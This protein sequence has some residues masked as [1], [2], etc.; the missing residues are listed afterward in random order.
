MTSTTTSRPGARGPEWPTWILI[1]CIYGSWAGL[2]LGYASLPTWLSNPALILVTTW[3]MS[4]QH[5]LLHGHPT[6][7]AGFNRLLG[8][9]PLSAWYPYDIY[10]DS[11]LLHHR[12]ALLTLPGTDPESNYLRAEDYSRMGWFSRMLHWSMRTVVGRLLLGPGLT[13]AQVWADIWTG[14]RERGLSAVKTWAVHLGLLAMVLWWV[15]S[16]SGITPLHYLLG[17][18]YP[19]L[20]LAMLRSF[21]E[22]RPAQDPAHRIVIN[23]AGLFWG[24]LYLHNNLHAVHHRHPGLAWYRIPDHYRAHQEDY[25]QSNGGFLLKGYGPLIRRHAFTPVDTVIHPGFE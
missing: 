24:M 5:E 2:L 15:H 16:V 12:D 22:H 11:H 4:L 13:I 10:R 21:F 25:R 1:L 9:L 17:I 14:P 20:G 19:A 18:A 23:E 6:R 8:L 7:H 3:F